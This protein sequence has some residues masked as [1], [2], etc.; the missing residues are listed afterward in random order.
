MMLLG[1]QWLISKFVINCVL[2]KLL[3]VLYVID[4]LQDMN[5]KRAQSVQRWRLLL[6]CQ[7]A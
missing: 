1:K 3:V 4:A 7:Q 6:D 2:S 5:L